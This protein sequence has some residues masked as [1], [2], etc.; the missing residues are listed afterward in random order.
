LTQATL[1]LYLQRCA[2]T[3]PVDRAKNAD[4]AAFASFASASAVSAQPLTQPRYVRTVFDSKYYQRLLGYAHLL[5]A[6]HESA[7]L[8]VGLAALRS[9][10]APKPGV[11]HVDFEFQKSAQY[12]IAECSPS[13]RAAWDVLA[14]GAHQS[15]HMLTMDPKIVYLFQMSPVPLVAARAVDLPMNGPT[16]SLGELQTAAIRSLVAA[17]QPVISNV[18]ASAKS[19]SS[20]SSGKSKQVAAVLRDGHFTVDKFGTNMRESEQ[21][22]GATL[23]PPFAAL[24]SLSVDVGSLVNGGANASALQLHPQPQHTIQPSAQQPQSLQQQMQKQYPQSPLVPPPRSPAP[25]QQQ[26]Q[27]TSAAVATVVGGVGAWLSYRASSFTA[28]S[29]AS[30]SLGA[31]IFGAGHAVRSPPPPSN[32]QQQTPQNRRAQAAI[33]MPSEA[34]A[35]MRGAFVDSPL[36]PFAATL[37][38]ELADAD[39]EMEEAA[40]SDH[41]GNDDLTAV[42]DRVGARASVPLA[43]HV[44]VDPFSSW[45]IDEFQ[46]PADATR[47]PTRPSSDQSKIDL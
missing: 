18:S 1:P 13:L 40:Q 3:S 4:P 16:A 12:V 41:D 10:L 21:L 19:S 38:D 6:F 25:P 30:Q 34:G 35:A 44:V 23:T 27:S 36:D 28:G 46:T 37:H 2:P 45:D 15:K 22:A 47:P 42:I 29:R 17:L 8:P 20:T 7:A 26:T 39:D 43:E 33:N 14:V 31:A 32:H 9:F 24:I 5:E 11:H